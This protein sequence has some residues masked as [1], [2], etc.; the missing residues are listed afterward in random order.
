MS[1]EIT[2]KIFPKY[3]PNPLV[4]SLPAHLKDPKNYQKIQKALIQAGM[5]KH[6]HG[7]MVDWAACAHCQRKQHDRAEM[8]R[9]LGFTSGAQYMKWKQIHEQIV[10][11][12]Q[13]R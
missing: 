1:D 4:A 8:M 5:S 12:V 2:P 11:R 7:E 9:K 3:R 6:S 10:R 13:L